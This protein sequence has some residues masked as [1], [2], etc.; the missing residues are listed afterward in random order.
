MNMCWGRLQVRSITSVA[1][2]D[3]AWMVGVG[4]G[5]GSVKGGSVEAAEA[6][7]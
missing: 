1:G 4:V 3:K 7:I 5:V 2:W 6:I